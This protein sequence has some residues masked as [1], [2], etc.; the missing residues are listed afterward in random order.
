MTQFVIMG[1]VDEL[2]KSASVK[3]WYDVA[4]SAALAGKTL[5]KGRPQHLKKIVGVAQKAAANIGSEAKVEA[6]K[7][8]VNAYGPI[9]RILIG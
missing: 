3:D 4:R 6:L 8:Y 1:F 9:H 7:A 2:S 5:V